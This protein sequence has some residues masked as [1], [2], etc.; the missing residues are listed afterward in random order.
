M[1][2][3]PML[4]DNPGEDAQESFGTSVRLDWSGLD[5]LE[6]TSISALAN[7]AISAMAAI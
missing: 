5:N 7:T 1:S 6:V 4:S 3:S 2:H